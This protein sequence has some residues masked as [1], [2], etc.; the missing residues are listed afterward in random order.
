MARFLGLKSYRRETSEALEQSI[1][2]QL[3][4]NANVKCRA[5]EKTLW[6]Y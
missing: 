5:A 1:K 6:W 4:S 3:A 2:L